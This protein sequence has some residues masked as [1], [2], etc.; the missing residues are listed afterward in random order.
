METRTRR[1]RRLPGSGVAAMNSTAP[2]RRAPRPR[3]LPDP[4]QAWPSPAR[5]EL[6]ALPLLVPAG[7]ACRIL[8]ISRKFLNRMI[9]GKRIRAMKTEDSRQGRVL[10]ARDSLVTFLRDGLAL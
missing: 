2:L 6:C 9:R 10:V 3:V 8:G 4:R 1:E 5:D 7:R